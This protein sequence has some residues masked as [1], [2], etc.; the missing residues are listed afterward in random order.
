MPRCCP[1]HP[2]W[3]PGCS[4]ALPEAVVEVL[5]RVVGGAVEGFLDVRDRPLGLPVLIQHEPQE[6]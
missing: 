5:V 6:V 1:L 3:S 4:Q 2:L